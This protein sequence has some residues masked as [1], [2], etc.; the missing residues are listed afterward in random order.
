MADE[1]GLWTAADERFVTETRTEGGPDAEPLHEARRDP[2]A[3]RR[4]GVIAAEHV[5][6]VEVPRDRVLDRV[7]ERG[8]VQRL[9][10]AR[11]ARARGG[12]PHVV[13]ALRLWIRQR[14][15]QIRVDDDERGGRQSHAQAQRDEGGNRKAAIFQQRADGKTEISQQIAPHA[16]R[17]RREGVMLTMGRRQSSVA[18]RQSSVG[19]HQSSVTVLS[20]SRQS[21][22]SL[23]K[24][25][26]KASEWA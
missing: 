17:T 24:F 13:E 11:L 5:E 16:E 6:H 14:A 10:P 2:R 1:R 9:H 18:G 25:C 22:S 4:L 15:Q 26:A 19:S 12:V 8:P 7:V 21:Q 3:W 23:S 20:P